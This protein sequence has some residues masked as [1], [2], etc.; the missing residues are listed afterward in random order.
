LHESGCVEPHSS[1]LSIDREKEVF[2]SEEYSKVLH[3][4]SVQRICRSAASGANG[5][6]KSVVTD[7]R[8]SAVCSGGLAR[9]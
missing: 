2:P 3:P 1:L 9:C 7:A 5:T 8:R 4:L 6:C